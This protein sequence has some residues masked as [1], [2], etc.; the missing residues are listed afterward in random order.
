MTLSNMIYIIYLLYEIFKL[1][2]FKAIKI[3]SIAGEILSKIDGKKSIFD[4]TKGICNEYSQI[5][6]SEIQK[7]VLRI[8]VELEEKK[9]II[10]DMGS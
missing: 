3:Q 7:D 2:L 9:L 4:I 1:S 5:D 10:F 8:C 6:E